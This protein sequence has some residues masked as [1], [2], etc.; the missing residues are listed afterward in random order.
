[1]ITFVKFY[2]NY[3]LKKYHKLLIYMEKNKNFKTADLCDLYSDDLVIMHQQFNS[4][5]KKEA[6]FGKISTIKCLNDNSKVR[7]AVNSNGL[8]KVL[9]I[10]GNASMECALLGDILAEAAFKNNWSGIIVNGCIRDSDIIANIDIGVLALSTKPVKSV[11]KGIG[12]E[13]IDVRFMG[14][15]FKPG[16]F[17]YADSDGI[18]MSQTEL[19]LTK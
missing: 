6:F 1:M 17:I 19:D 15:T 4:Y 18:I 5:G 10:D 16:D 9:I 14:V 3:F 2:L 8:N 13:N 11:K 12:D 7:E